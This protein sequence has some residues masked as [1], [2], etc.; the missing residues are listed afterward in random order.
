MPD[1]SAN[2]LSVFVLAG[3]K[4]TRMGSDKAFLQHEGR[5]LLDRGLSVARSISADVWIV[6][7]KQK[8]PT[9]GRVLEDIF[10]ERGPLGG[11]H[12]ALL[13]SQTDRNLMLAVDM[14]FVSPRFLGYLVSV[15]RASGV[16]AVIPRAEGRLQPLCA[17]YR[18][19]F[20]ATAEAALRAGNNKIGPLFA[21]VSIRVIE[22][23]E[24]VHCG[25]SRDLFRNL[26]TPQDLAALD[27]PPG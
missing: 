9:Y 18:R 11:I 23:E 27:A 12:A 21:G 2:N 22:E 17:I 5:T 13:A 16:T 15:A 4:S 14:P 7:S 10:P 20:A 6:G 3:G 1:A 19:D 8:F 25:F 26:N 24:L